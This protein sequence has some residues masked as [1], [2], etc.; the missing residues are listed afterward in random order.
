MAELCVHRLIVGTVS[1]RGCADEIRI[2]LAGRRIDGRRSQSSF[3]CARLGLS[4]G[5]TFRRVDGLDLG[6]EQ[7]CKVLV[8]S[9]LQVSE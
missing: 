5:G 1:S 7:I 9:A 6:S 3:W 8:I 2:M 4:E